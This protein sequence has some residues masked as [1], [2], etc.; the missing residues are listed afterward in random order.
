METLNLLF[1]LVLLFF[2]YYYIGACSN[3]REKGH[4]TAKYLELEKGK[5]THMLTLA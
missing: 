2:L 4:I 3:N 5:K 1:K